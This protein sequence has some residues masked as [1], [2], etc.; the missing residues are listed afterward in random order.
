MPYIPPKND[1]PGYVRGLGPD[2]DIISRA[3][4][5]QINNLKTRLVKNAT[6]SEKFFRTNVA[7]KLYR[8]TNH[9]VR[10]V[11]QK[12]FL[13][14]KGITFIVDFY[15]PALKIAV[16]ID[17]RQHS[18]EYGAAKDGWR[19]DVLRE[20]GIFTL[21]YTNETVLTTPELVWSDILDKAISHTGTPSLRRR[22]QS[23]RESG[24]LPYI[25]PK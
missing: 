5:I 9:R 20:L 16:E 11:F 24:Q 17:G 22:L 12:E 2:P 7:A 6:E 8:R 15:F 21:H 23:M 3:Q 19:T 18:S 13:V 4:Q 10:F 14:A 25:W 1:N